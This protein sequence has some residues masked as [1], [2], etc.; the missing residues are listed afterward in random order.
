MRSHHSV[1]YVGLHAILQSASLT[2]YLILL[3]VGSLTCHAELNGFGA[4]RYL[5]KE[6]LASQLEVDCKLTHFYML[7]WQLQTCAITMNMMAGPPLFKRAIVQTGEARAMLHP[8]LSQDLEE[9]IDK[10]C[11][12]T[13]ALMYL[14]QNG[15]SPHLVLLVHP[16]FMWH[17][18]ALTMQCNCC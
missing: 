10:R 12:P 4:I 1:Q 7:I 11:N 9:A 3:V 18:L 16:N 17:S 15:F 6:L 2:S 14:M 13:A 5:I 8:A